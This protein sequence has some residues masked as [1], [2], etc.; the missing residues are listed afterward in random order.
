M[1]LVQGDMWALAWDVI[2]EQLA[3]GNQALAHG[4]ALVLELHIDSWACDVLEHERDDGGDG[5]HD[6]C[7]GLDASCDH[8]FSCNACA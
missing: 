4:M 6:D 5:D 3:Y 1:A 8:T 2:L 7:D